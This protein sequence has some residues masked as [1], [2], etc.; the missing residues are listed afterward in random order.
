MDEINLSRVASRF[1][2]AAYPA[3][4][5]TIADACADTRVLYADGSEPLCDVI[6][7]IEADRFETPEDLFVAVQNVLPVE[8]VG[9]PGQ[10]DGDA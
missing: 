8:A 3:E 2:A 6:D 7:R 4:K 1:E 10:S 9:E 5:A